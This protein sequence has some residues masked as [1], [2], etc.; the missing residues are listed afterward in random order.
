LVALEPRLARSWY[1]LLRLSE[2]E[3]LAVSG[4]IARSGDHQHRKPLRHLGDEYFDQFGAH[5]RAA[6]RSENTIANYL[7]DLRLFGR[8]FAQS[9]DEPMAPQTVTV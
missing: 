8:W 3:Q 9:N 4:P 5:L 1:S 6:D 7:T 2:T